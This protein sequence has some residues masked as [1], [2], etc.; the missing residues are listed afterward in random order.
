MIRDEYKEIEE[1]KVAKKSSIRD[2]YTTKSKT[3]KVSFKEAEAIRKVGARSYYSSRIPKL[4]DGIKVYKFSAWFVLI[5][6]IVMSIMTLLTFLTSLVSPTEVVLDVEFYVYFAFSVAM[7]VYSILCFA[8]FVPAT[9]KKIERYTL[10]LKEV[11]ETDAVKRNA[12]YEYFLK[13]L[14]NTKGE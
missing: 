9:K 14:N 1:K 7:L 5:I 6:G 12:A 3:E 4:R 11:N 8:V 13:N 10:A 2:E